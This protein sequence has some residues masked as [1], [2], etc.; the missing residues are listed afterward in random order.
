M[1]RRAWLVV[2]LVLLVILT[3]CV[4]LWVNEGPLWRIVM[5]EIIPLE[6]FWGL[7]SPGN[8]RPSTAW[9]TVKRWTQPPVPHGPAICYWDG[10][11]VK[12]C[13]AMW[14]DGVVVR[15]TAWNRDGAVDWQCRADDQSKTRVQNKHFPLP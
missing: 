6:D 1:R 5:T 13:E 4:S 12:A 11:R 2:V 3:L 8:H 9:L 15:F 10:T 7:C 14:V